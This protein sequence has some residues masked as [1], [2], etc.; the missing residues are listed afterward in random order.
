MHYRCAAVFVDDVVAPIGF[1]VA[2]IVLHIVATLVSLVSFPK[3]LSDIV[4]D[5]IMAS[6]RRRRPLVGPASSWYSVRGSVRDQEPFLGISVWRGDSGESQM[7]FLG[8]FFAVGFH[9]LGTLGR[10]GHSGDIAS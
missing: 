3:L 5:V 9:S 6:W 10:F 8:S 7:S 4:A 1:S 2:R